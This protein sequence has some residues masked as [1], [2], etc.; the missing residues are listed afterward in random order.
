AMGEANQGGEAGARVVSTQREQVPRSTHLLALRAHLRGHAG[1]ALNFRG[2]P[3]GSHS[4]TY[5]SPLLATVRAWGAPNLSGR[6]GMSAGLTS[7][8]SPRCATTLSSA[9]RMVT[10]DSSSGT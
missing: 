9:S 8:P 10:R 5:R 2:R 3:Y 4:M 1:V 7:L 6:P